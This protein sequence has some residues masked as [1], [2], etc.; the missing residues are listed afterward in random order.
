MTSSNRLLRECGNATKHDLYIGTVQTAVWHKEEWCSAFWL[1][2]HIM[3]PVSRTWRCHIFR[4]GGHVVLVKDSRMWELCSFCWIL[5][6]LASCHLP[7]CAENYSKAQWLVQCYQWLGVF[8]VRRLFWYK[9]SH[10][11]T[12][13]VGRRFLD[14]H[15]R[16]SSCVTCETVMATPRPL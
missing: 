2:C 15:M 6:E 4:R 9:N 11:W 3:T 13:P 7:A 14:L 12:N 5:K 10:T 1:S 16:S 8:E